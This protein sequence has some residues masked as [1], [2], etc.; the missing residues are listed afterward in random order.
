M[1]QVHPI[2]GADA[3]NIRCKRT[4]YTVLMHPIYGANAPN[5]RCW[6]TVYT[7]W[8]QGM[9]VWKLS[10][11]PPVCDQYTSHLRR[12][13]VASARYIRRKCEVYWSQKPPARVALA[14]T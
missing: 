8:L 2:Y 9:R 1:V 13:L 14:R 10:T 11:Y 5:I 7:F 12:I 4:Q 6:C 3:P